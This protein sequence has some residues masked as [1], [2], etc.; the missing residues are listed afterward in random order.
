M[1]SALHH[2]L[3][4]KNLRVKANIIV[5]TASARDNHQI[6]CLIGFGA[7]A[8][9][10]TLAYQTILD[11]SNRNELQGS[12]HSNCARYRKGININRASL[13]LF[14]KGTKYLAGTCEAS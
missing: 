10:P 14:E 6:A 4:E 8:V 3:I 13:F 5:N 7:T 1:T 12:P 9:Y 2:K 11:L